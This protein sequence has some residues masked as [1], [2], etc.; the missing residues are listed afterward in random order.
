MRALTKEELD[1]VCGGWGSNETI[2]VTGHPPTTSW[3][4]YSIYQPPSYYNPPPVNYTP[5]A[6]TPAQTIASHVTLS[7]ITS[8]HLTAAKQAQQNITHALQNIDAQLRALPTTQKVTWDGQT[9]TVGAVIN[10]LE[11][12]NWVIVEP[13]TQTSGNGG[14]GA[15]VGSTDYLSYNAFTST[16]GSWADPAWNGEGMEFIMLHELGHM[17]GTAG[18]GPFYTNGTGGL[19][20]NNENYGFFLN[21][22]TMKGVSY[23]SSIY[24]R[25]NEAFA[26]NFAET[27]A[28]AFNVNIADVVASVNANAS[29]TGG[30]SWTNP[31]TIY[32][33]DGGKMPQ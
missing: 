12:E 20:Q 24:W 17:T 6:P 29:T 1:L 16:T 3:F 31:Q 5:P 2:F 9:T 26:N 18:T 8:A 30:S 22:P 32:T 7:G 23:P 21:D 19:G 13:G 4:P 11:N 15:I 28:A 27:E 14:V 10:I 33:N 25:N